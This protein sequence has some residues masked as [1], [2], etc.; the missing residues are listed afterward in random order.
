MKDK[1]FEIDKLLNEVYVLLNDLTNDDRKIGHAK[2]GISIA[3]DY[4]E[5]LIRQ[6]D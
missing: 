2:E 5:T 1:L 3:L 4:V 6:Q